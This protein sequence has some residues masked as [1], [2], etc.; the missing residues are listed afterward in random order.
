MQCR[1][2]KTELEHVFIDLV[3]SP[4]SNSFLTKEQ[5]NEPETFYPLKVYTCHN[6]FLVQVD[7]YKKSDAIFDS[8]YAYFS[9]Y[10]TS[11]L[12]HAKKY[13]DMMVERFGFNESSQVIEIASNDG[14][15]LQYFKEKN[16]PVMGIEPTANTA[17]VAVGKGIK[18]IIEFF[19]VELA[20]RLANHWEVKA[21]LLLGNNVLAHVPDIVDFVGGM[22][23]ILA[24]KGVITMEFPHLMQLVDNNQFD[25][26]Y[27]EHFSYLSCHTVKQIFEA[28]ELELFD[29]DEIP[30]HGGSLRIY[31]KHKEDNSKEISPN[32]AKL[33]Q[34]E[35]GKEMTGLSYYDN[36]QQ[37]ALQ[38]K[39]DITSFL[40]EQKRAGKNVAAY[41]A[42]AK[43]NT[44]L[45]YCGIKNDLI[46]YVVDANPHKQ[47][48]WMPASHIPVVNEEHL[49]SKKPD[50]VIILPWNLKDE[51]VGQLSYIKEWGG[52]FVVP[53]PKLQMI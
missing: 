53:I 11:W 32:V 14:Y 21:D 22:K 50:F 1:F 23:I 19:G 12:A 34:K 20:D 25:T 39:L 29:V 46:E 9:S 13:T 37:K 16:I 41:G 3:N 26:I 15:L 27:H 7:E 4:A 36:F 6:C 10:S 5:L 2:C 40:I 35:A 17:E 49:K 8:N 44:L 51:I 43:G 48:K 28:A 24:D 31:A 45:N 47:N 18:T 33:L 42:A 38:V 52:Q 30:T